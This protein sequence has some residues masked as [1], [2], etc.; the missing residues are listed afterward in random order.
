MKGYK[1]FFQLQNSLPNAKNPFVNQP[2]SYNEKRAC[3]IE[4]KY[5]IVSFIY[6]IVLFL[7]QIFEASIKFSHW[8]M[9]KKLNRSNK[10]IK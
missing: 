1:K 2:T 8:H 9:I 6:Q 10:S 4:F 3:K 7:Y 5:F